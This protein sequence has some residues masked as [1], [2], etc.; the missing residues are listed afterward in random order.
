VFPV[1]TVTEADT[2]ETFPAESKEAMSGID[3]TFRNF[4]TGPEKYKDAP[5]ALQI[6]TR[7]LR[8]EQAL[9]LAAELLDILK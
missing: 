1:G 9:M 4:Y 8:E 3:A 7:R 5:V 6:V 2:W